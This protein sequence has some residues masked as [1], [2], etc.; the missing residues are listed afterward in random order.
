MRA[1]ALRHLLTLQQAT[2]TLN[3]RGEGVPT[4]ADEAELWGEI[5]PLTGREGLQ[6][7]QMFASATHFIRVR[8]RAGIVPKK[9]FVKGSRV[10][11]IDY[12]RNVNERNRELVCTVTERL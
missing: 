2:D 11:D 1:G 12:V 4:W 7:A 5:Q 10:F 6:A 8:Y 9:R 3:A